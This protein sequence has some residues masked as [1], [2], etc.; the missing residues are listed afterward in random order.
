MARAHAA[1]VDASSGGRLRIALITDAWEPQTNGVVTTLRNTTRELERRG[2]EVLRV[3][4]EQFATIP[5]P[6][7]PEIRFAVGAR[8]RVADRLDSF[9]PDAVHVA[10]EGPLGLAARAACRQRWAFT[11]SYHTQFPE[12]VRARWPVPLAAGY[13][14]L[15]WFHRRASRTLVSTPTVRRALE[16]RGF[17]RLALWSRGV[18]T[19]LFRPR[20]GGLEALP[21]PI[22]L[23]AGRVAVEK[24]ILAFVDMDFPGTKVVVG[25]GP[26]L[27]S[28]RARRPGVHYTGLLTGEHLAEAIAAADVFV[29]PS[30]T[31]T[32]GVVMLEAMACGVPVAAHPVTGPID[33]VREGVSGA[34]R[35][36]LRA[37]VDA[38][39]RLDRRAVRE[40][41]LEH[42]W[43]RATGQFL[44]ALVPARNAPASLRAPLRAWRA[45]A[46]ICGVA[47]LE[48]D[49]RHAASAPGPEA[50]V[51]AALAR[52]RIRGDVAAAELERVPAR[53]P[54]VVVANHPFGGADG[55]VVLDALLRRRPDLRVLATRLIAG[56]GPI[57]PLLLPVDNLQPKRSRAANSVQLLRALRWVRAGGALLMFPAGS[58]SHVDVQAGCVVDPPWSHAAAR[59][60]R[61]AQAPVLPVFV[62]GRNSSAFQAAG[63][64]HPALRTLLLPLELHRKRG[65]IIRLRIGEP[66]S[67]ARIAA[68]GSDDDLAAKLRLGVYALAAAEEPI[69]TGGSATGAATPSARRHAVAP[70]E[71]ITAPMDPAV[72]AVNVARLGD[73]RRL[74]RCGALD[75]Y[76]APACELPD[77]LAEIGRLREL[78]FRAAGEGTG[79]A[80]D[81]DRF[82]ASYEHL[83]AWDRRA[84]RIVGGYRIGRVDEI[85]HAAGRDGL[86]LNTLFD[87]REP[88]LT[89]LG[90]A[91]ELGR[92]FVR[93]EYQ[94][95]FGPL[96]ALWRGIAAYVAREPRYVRLLGPV[97][98][99][100]DY[101]RVSIELIVRFLQRRHFDPLLGSF[102]RPRQPFRTSPSLA[103]LGAGLAQLPG[104]E[105]LSEFVAARD[106]QRR[107]VPVLLRQY[108]G[109][110]G[111]VLGFHVD[112]AFGGCVDCLTVVDLRR[113]PDAT[114]AK[115]MD[116]TQL[117]AFRSCGSRRRR[118]SG[119]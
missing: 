46:P 89:L 79:H 95:S 40:A 62:A 49:Y 118:I 24:N 54:L 13:R 80:T 98:I 9:A 78:T 101:D 57:A 34:L 58:V 93:P 14:Y 90:P 105:A 113:T 36:D 85:R 94:R 8:S 28:L 108:L 69:D 71:P 110:G 44:D 18:D 42:S 47:E 83:F 107:G 20:A 15:H 96:L 39:L 115:Y 4:P 91:L 117:A 33:V 41:A 53:G 72:V 109:L 43:S 45:V 2:C 75:V 37:A 87:L 59:L 119:P 51:R 19:D 112:A 17:A 55:L 52:L 114:L 27:A 31:D 81:L 104:L 97:S 82:D 26:L 70:P 12:Y 66:W 73:E 67:P 76:A 56:V 25:D 1:G 64:L 32:F 50:F 86:Y 29:F 21:R 116:A 103:T 10:T 22:A 7:Y 11:T 23:Y 3:S 6:S 60:L 99:A 65:A 100:G 88:L 84:A 77:V 102:A 74:A 48:G 38:A 5:C 63:V 30:R 68:G 111:R 35:D 106:P 61:R 92:S 16:R